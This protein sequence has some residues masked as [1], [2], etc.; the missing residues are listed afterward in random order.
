MRRGPPGVTRKR[1]KA[2]DR[3][4]AGNGLVCTH[5]STR[6]RAECHLAV[7]PL[8][9]AKCFRAVFKFD[10]CLLGRRSIWGFFLPIGRLDG[11]SVI[12]GVWQ[13]AHFTGYQDRLSHRLRAQPRGAHIF[14]PARRRPQFAFLAR[15][16]G[17]TR[18]VVERMQ[19]ARESLLLL[20][21]LGWA[22]RLGHEFTRPAQR[23]AGL[24]Y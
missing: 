9:L 23:I 13:S 2:S 15:D 7:G 8:Q 1:F 10:D 16:L 4:D 22:A 11:D 24:C 5:R 19:C 12:T 6:Y 21:R 17:Q 18:R 20:L 3:V 14:R